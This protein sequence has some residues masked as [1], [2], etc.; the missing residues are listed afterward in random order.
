LP[1]GWEIRYTATGRV[2]YVD[3]TNRTTQFTDPRLSTNLE[4]IQRRLL[5]LFTV[6]SSVY[7]FNVL[8]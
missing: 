3:H 6:L 5:V 2:Y 8:Q 7:V 1:T 4:A